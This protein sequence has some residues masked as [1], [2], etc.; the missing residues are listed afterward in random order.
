MTNDWTQEV[1]ELY[2]KLSQIAVPA[3]AEQIATLLALIPFAADEAFRMAVT[4]K[5]VNRV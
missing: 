4:R 3:R 5:V 1:S 2:R